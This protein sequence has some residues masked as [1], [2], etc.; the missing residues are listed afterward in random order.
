[1]KCTGGYTQIYYTAYLATAPQPIAH[2]RQCCE[3]KG[4]NAGAQKR[5]GRRGRGRDRR[6]SVCSSGLGS[7]DGTRAVDCRHKRW[8][9]KNAPVSGDGTESRKTK[10]DVRGLQRDE[11]QEVGHQSYSRLGKAD[12]A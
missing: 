1:M 3:L 7:A 10:L 12:H 11:N 9:R 4:S 2:L 5:Q 6:D 8:K